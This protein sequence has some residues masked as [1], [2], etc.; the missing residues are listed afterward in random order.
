MLAINDALGNEVTSTITVWRADAASAGRP[1]A[2][3][4]A[5]SSSNTD[6]STPRSPTPAFNKPQIL[7]VLDRHA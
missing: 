6:A 5:R 7:G 2:F 1:R 4:L 3:S